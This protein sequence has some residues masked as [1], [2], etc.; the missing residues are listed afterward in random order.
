MTIFISLSYINV[1]FVVDLNLYHVSKYFSKNFTKMV[2][3]AEVV[4]VYSMW[5]IVFGTIG[6][7]ITFYVCYQLRS[8][9]TFV[10][11]AFMAITDL[12]SLYYWNLKNFL[13]AFYAIDISRLSIYSCR[14]NS[15]I[16]FAS[17]Y[18]SAWL[19]VS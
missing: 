13:T 6:N 4:G 16:Q 12:V 8:T 18:T 1:L 17:L 3:I 14:I 2:S 11:F 10:F 5:L 19:L 9:T 15:F 7:L